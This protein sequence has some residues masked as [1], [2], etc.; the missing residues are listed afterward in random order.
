MLRCAPCLAESAGHPVPSVTVLPE[1]RGGGTSGSP[2]PTGAAGTRSAQVHG[3]APRHPPRRSD[4]GLEGRREAAGETERGGGGGPG[5]PCPSPRGRAPRR[6]EEKGCSGGAGPRWGRGPRPDSHSPPHSPPG[7]SSTAV[8]APALTA[9]VSSRGSTPSA[10]ARSCGEV[11]ARGGRM[12]SGAEGV[13]K[14]GRS[15]SPP[16]RTPQ[17]RSP[18]APL[19]HGSCGPSHHTRL[20]PSTPPDGGMI[21][22]FANQR[23]CEGRPGGLREEREREGYGGEEDGGGTSCD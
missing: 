9:R 18:P 5:R 1:R 23:P 8:P 7:P 3:R 16:P 13:E 19:S 10:D 11:G 14:M 2:V 22:A 4:A 6:G 12:A 20:P 15:F 17:T 21:A